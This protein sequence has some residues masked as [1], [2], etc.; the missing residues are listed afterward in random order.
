MSRILIVGAG[1]VGKAT[2]KGFAKKG[3][4]IT[5][6]DVVPATLEKLR[7][8]GLRAMTMSEVDWLAVDVVMICVPTP[9]LNDRIVLEYIATAADEIGCGLAKTDQFI[10]V[11]VRSTVPPTTTEQLIL[12]VLEEASDKKAGVDFGLAMNPEFLR[13]ASSEQDFLRPWI[14]VLG[15]TDLRTTQ[16]L[17]DVYAPFGSLI[18]FCTPTE[19]E[20]VKYTSNVYNALKI[21]YFNEIDSLCQNLAIDSQLVG[22]IVARTAEAMW[23]PLYGTK[24]GVPFGGACLPKDTAAYVEFARQFGIDPVMVDATIAVNKSLEQKIAAV[25]SPDQIDAALAQRRVSFVQKTD[26]ADGDQE[27]A[28]VEVIAQNTQNE[29]MGATL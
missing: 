1:V 28:L 29:S 10:A 27:N 23:N 18:A 13:Q 15:C 22:S 5:F 25:A 2:G 21:S 7:V 4:D 3:H 14:T 8:E 11:V 6:V 24:G 12:P 16:L 19:A 26:E 9:T 20:M 17:R